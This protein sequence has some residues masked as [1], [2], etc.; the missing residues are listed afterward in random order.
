[1]ISRPTSTNA[2]LAEHLTARLETALAQHLER[3]Q[4]W[5][6]HE[7]VPWGQASDFAELSWEESHS[8][9][10]PAVRASVQLNLLTEDNLPGYHGGKNADL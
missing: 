9:L 7:Y 6:P 3:A 4:Q 8:R 10:T 1:M 5:Y 2:A